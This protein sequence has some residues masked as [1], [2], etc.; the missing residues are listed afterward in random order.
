MLKI[1]KKKNLLKS[2]LLNFIT[3]KT[4]PKSKLNLEKKEDNFLK[5]QKTNKQEILNDNKTSLLSSW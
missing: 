1:L 3:V 5:D 2:I 4:P